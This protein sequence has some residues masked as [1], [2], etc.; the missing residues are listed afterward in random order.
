MA[1]P[2]LWCVW[3]GRTSST[4]SGAAS[5]PPTCRP[6]SS[7]TVRGQDSS[8]TTTTHPPATMINEAD[9][10]VPCACAPLLRQPTTGEQQPRVR[11]DCVSKQEPG[12]SRRSLLTPL[13]P[14][15]NALLCCHVSTTIIMDPQ[16]NGIGGDAAATEH[17]YG[18]AWKD[19][20]VRPPAIAVTP[21]YGMGW[22]SRRQ[23]WG[24]RWRAMWLMLGVVT[25][26]VEFFL[27]GELVRTTWLPRPLKP[28]RIE[29]RC[30]FP[31]TTI[32]SS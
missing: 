28:M 27:N 22:V 10:A 16:I 26:Q 15:P 9:D 7:C 2:I 12:S 14:P 1:D 3:P 5:T 24:W 4:S 6:T 11:R 23:L 17:L 25:W 31:D 21:R 8:S 19:K 29:A 30:V 13:F 18:V 32:R 20:K